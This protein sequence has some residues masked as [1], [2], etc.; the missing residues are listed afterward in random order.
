MCFSTDKS[1]KRHAQPNPA[2]PPHSRRA[3]LLRRNHQNA[4]DNADVRVLDVVVQSHEK[5]S[6]HEHKA[7]RVMIYRNAGTQSFQYEDGRHSTFSFKDNEVKWSPIEGRHI[8]E[9][10]IKKLS[11]EELSKSN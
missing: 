9:A 3:A 1:P 7:N 6:M 10:F 5:T 2:H 4:I 11:S 8:A